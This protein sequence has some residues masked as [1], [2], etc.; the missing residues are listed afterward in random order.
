MKKNKKTS[1]KE[2]KDIIVFVSSKETKCDD[3]AQLIS[4]NEFIKLTRERKAY[5]MACSDLDHLIF[6]PSGD[7]CI[8]RRA[9]KY[10]ILNAIVMQWSKSRR[11]NERQGI[12]AEEDAITKAEEDCLDDFEIR[13]IQKKRN[14]ERRKIID[15]QYVQKFAE[16]IKLYFPKCPKSTSKKIAEHACEKYS[17]RVGRSANAKEFDAEAVKLAVIAHIRHTK[18]NY[19]S[20][21][22]QGYAKKEA[23]REIQVKLENVLRIWED[24]E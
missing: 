5:C 18:T 2:S 16:V 7:A 20:L 13:E 9:R 24:I 1:K 22:M 15:K 8:S 12:L 6:L 17:G 19:D 4:K 3:C 11:R 21:L 14:A 10:S 23:R